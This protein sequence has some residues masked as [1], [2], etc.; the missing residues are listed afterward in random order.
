MPVG[1][2]YDTGPTNSVKYL[3]TTNT[4]I[5]VGDLVGGTTYHC[6]VTARYG[7]DWFSWKGDGNEGPK[8]A[9]SSTIT[10]PVTKPVAPTKVTATAPALPSGRST[11]VR[12]TNP[13]NNSGAPILNDTATCTS[14]DGGTT[15]TATGT[16]SPLTVNDLTA[17]KTYTCAVTARNSQG[18]SDPSGASTAIVVPA[19][20]PTNVVAGAPTK[21]GTKWRST[22]TFTRPSGGPT[23]T[24]YT[25]TCTPTGSG[26]PVT[27]ST[28]TANTSVWVDGL[29]K[30]KTYR[31]TVAARSGSGT[32]PTSTQS[33]PITVPNA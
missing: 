2:N 15:R 28:S 11:Q 33:N 19:G 18:T 27:V 13:T 16:S 25:V 9:W 31:C 26:S 24:G 20:P 12:F 10:V 7:P 22:V 1:T 17:G 5:P 4:T 8:S 29:V 30:G 32:G 23:I 6:L 14:T 3:G 21:V